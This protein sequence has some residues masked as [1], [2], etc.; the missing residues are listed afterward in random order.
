MPPRAGR[1][2]RR[3]VLADQERIR[4]DV[5]LKGQPSMITLGIDIGTSGVKVALVGD[6]DHVIGASSQPLRR[7]PPAPGLE[8]AV[9]RR[10]VG[11]HLRRLTS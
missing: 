3:A 9:A 10:L 5:F 2:V 6:D 4:I 8:R 7:Q 1:A 11:R